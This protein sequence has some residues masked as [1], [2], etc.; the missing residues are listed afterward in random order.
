M[1]FKTDLEPPERIQTQ[2]YIQLS[3][4]GNPGLGIFAWL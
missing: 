3:V 4:S 1:V 2:D